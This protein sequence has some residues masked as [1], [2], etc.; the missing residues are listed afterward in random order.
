[1]SSSEVICKIQF[2]SYVY[3][4]NHGY[5]QSL[6]NGYIWVDDIRE[7][8]FSLL[9]STYKSEKNYDASLLVMHVRNIMSLKQAKE[10]EVS[11]IH[12]FGCTE[13]QQK[14]KFTYVS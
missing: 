2:K 13:Y 14:L 8:P 5:V 1:M 11:F 3:I 10:R 12:K 6:W 9:V 4:L 7:M